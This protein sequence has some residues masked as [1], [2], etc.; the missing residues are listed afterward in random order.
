M[1]GLRLCGLCVLL[2]ANLASAAAID[3]FSPSGF[4]GEQVRTWKMSDARIVANAP[5]DFDP[6][7]PTLLVFYACPNGNSIEQ[8]LG[9]R[10]EPGMDWHFDIQHIAAQIRKLR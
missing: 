2:I 1:R 10:L 6:R 7:K 9:C 4:R 8:T 3:G 5:G